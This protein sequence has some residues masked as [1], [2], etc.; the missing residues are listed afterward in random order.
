MTA[1]Y[2]EFALYRAQGFILEDMSLQEK[3]WGLGLLFLP[4]LI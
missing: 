2:H 4:A 3:L 1:A